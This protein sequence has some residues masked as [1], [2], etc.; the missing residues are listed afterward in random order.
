MSTEG[1]Y[2]ESELLAMLTQDNEH[3]FESIFDH[4]RNKIY[5][6]TNVY[7][8]SP[9]VAEEI[10]QDVFLKLWLERS[11]IMEIRSLEAWLFT[12]AKNL[13][14]NHIKKLAHEWKVRETWMKDAPKLEDN[15]DHR[16]RNAQY[17]ELIAQ[18]F[19]NLSLQ[20]KLIYKMGKEEGLSYEAIGKK[21]SISPLTVKTHMARALQAMRSFLL[22]HGQAFIL[23]L[24]LGKKHF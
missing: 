1:I 10:V 17:Q 23:V 21:L 22:K 4:Y 13:V 11:S 19:N 6:I 18:A 12:L 7:V 5:R 16:I 20:Q 15:A 3:A 2:K 14:F 8:K 9:E 24:M